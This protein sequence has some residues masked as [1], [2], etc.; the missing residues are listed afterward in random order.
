MYPREDAEKV[1]R[2]WV[3]HTRGL[4]DEI[5]SDCIHWSIPEHE[6]LLDMSNIYPYSAVNKMFDPFLQK[7]TLYSYWKS[8]YVD[9]IFEE[10]LQLIIEKANQ[11]PAPQGL[12]SIRNLHG[13]LS[14]V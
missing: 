13:A 9:D 1:M 14:R 4:P 8:L 2:F 12:L 11:A 3:D 6:P 5:S 10:L 7:G